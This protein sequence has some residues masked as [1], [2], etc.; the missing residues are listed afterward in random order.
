MSYIPTVPVG[1][2]SVRISFPQDVRATDVDPAALALLAGGAGSF[3]MCRN[4]KAGLHMEGWDLVVDLPTISTALAGCVSDGWYG[5][6]LDG[7]GAVDTIHLFAAFQTEPV[8]SANQVSVAL[9]TVSPYQR[10]RSYTTSPVH[11]AP[12]VTIDILAEPLF[13]DAYPNRPHVDIVEGSQLVDV[14]GAAVLSADSSRIALTLPTDMS[15]TATA[16]RVR[17]YSWTGQAEDVVVPFGSPVPDLV[18]GYVTSVYEDLFGREPEAAG[19]AGWAATLRAGTPYSAVAD[20]ITSS[21]EFRST[22]IGTVYRDVLHRSPEPGGLA[23]WLG[24]MNVGMRIQ[25]MEAGILASPEC[26]ATSGGSAESW[27][28]WLYWI[29]LG[30]TPTD[31]EI[32]GW[33]AALG[34]GVSRFD[35][36]KGF[37]YSTEGLSRVVDGYYVDYLHRHADPGGVAGWVRAI[38]SGMR[39]EQIV[40]GIVGS[41]EY[42][43][44]VPRA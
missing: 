23:S 34:R 4:T 11:A 3:M 12:G 27:I 33:S 13:F 36:A 14:A 17:N 39:S 37:V 22:L 16:V 7:K 44:N 15:P 30:R 20:A 35:V 5:F 28:R 25:D 26:Y 43:Q 40:V 24:A 32:G 6:E 38:Q 29:V 2:S 1:A 18:D 21:A 41:A 31:S 19:L 9:G 8:N 42:R 10:T